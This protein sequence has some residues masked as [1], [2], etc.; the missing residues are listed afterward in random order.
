[1]KVVIKGSGT[2]ASICIDGKEIADNV[3]SYSISHLAG[4][5][6]T[7]SLILWTDEFDIELDDAEV[8]VAH[9]KSNS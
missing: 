5:T 1:M 3:C 9:A 4:A 6:P 8:E 7:L 2:T